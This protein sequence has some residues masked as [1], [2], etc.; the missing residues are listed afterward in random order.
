M[1]LSVWPVSLRAGTDAMG[2]HLRGAEL[3]PYGFIVDEVTT[4][5]S[6]SRSASEHPAQEVA[7]L[8][9]ERPQRAFHSYARQLADLLTSPQLNAGL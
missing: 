4:R 3:V 8:D 5:M 2:Q 6:A 7:A 1:E 9:A